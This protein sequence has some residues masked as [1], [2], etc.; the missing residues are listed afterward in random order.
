MPLTMNAKTSRLLLL[1]VLAVALAGFVVLD[2]GRYLSL[3]QLRAAQADL[4]DLYAR[5]PG[6]VVAAFFGVYVVVTALSLPGA[7]PLTLAGGALFGLGLG[8]LVV[9]FASTAGATLAML[10]SRHL[11]REAVQARF[12]ARLAEMDRGIARDGAFEA[13]ELV[14]DLRQ[15]GH[16]VSKA[17]VYRTIRLLLD[18][19]IITQSLFDA[20]QSH[21]ELLYGREP[22][23]CMVCM[24]T[25]R[26]VEFTSK[27]LVELRDR[28]CRDLG[29]QP[30]GHRFQIFAIA[31][32]EHT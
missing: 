13:E 29:W 21:Y 32:I 9:S 10:V 7:V 19:G 25:G 31:P 26:R 6:T 15:R 3:E 20:K 12:G 5:R 27:Q 14:F 2:L 22:R 30:I 16:D 8:T 17:T 18:A 24:K 4:A 11:L 28:I 1:L 23:D